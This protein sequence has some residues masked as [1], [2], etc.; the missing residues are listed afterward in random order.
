MSEDAKVTENEAE[1]AKAEEKPEDAKAEAKAEEKAEETPEAKAEETPEAKADE[2]PEAK[3][4]E[5]PEAKADEKAEEKPQANAQTRESVLDLA[6]GE[7]NDED[8]DALEV[9]VGTIDFATRKASDDVVARLEALHGRLGALIGQIRDG[10][11]PAEDDRAPLSEEALQICQNLVDQGIGAGEKGN[12][13]EAKGYLEEAVRLNPDGID[14]LFNLGVVYGL[15]AHHNI[16]RAEFYDNFV[17]DEVFV[18]R[19]Q[20]CYDHLLELVP[21]HLPSLNNLA[22]LYSVRDER[23]QAVPLLKRILTIEAGN[24][25]EKKLIASARSQLQELESI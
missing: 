10:V 2:T 4:E 7:V 15:L 22:T 19:A 6:R 14:A 11:R 3:A 23:D 18:E 8:L 17:R 13:E 1:D 16:A 24:D 12:L 9:A 5:T 21:D 25:D 20:I